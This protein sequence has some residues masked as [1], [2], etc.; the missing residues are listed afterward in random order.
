MKPS[1]SLHLLIRRYEIVSMQQNSNDRCF[2]GLSEPLHINPPFTSTS[3]KP[4][5]RKTIQHREQRRSI[6]QGGYLKCLA[7]ACA[8]AMILLASRTEAQ[9]ESGCRGD[10]N[11]LGDECE[12]FLWKEL[13]P[14]DP[15]KECCAQVQNADIQCLCGLV[16]KEFEKFISM[17]K[18]AH[19]AK[20]CQRPL[21]NGSKC[22]SKLGDLSSNIFLSDIKLKSL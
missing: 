20:Y 12:Q 16:T 5:R 21:K 1:S 6:M 3:S 2:T 18:L 4:T 17:A 14:K 11:R 9:N 22:G 10:F 8:M 15:S 19:V 13:P 7:I